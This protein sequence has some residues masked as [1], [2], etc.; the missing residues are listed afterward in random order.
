[1]NFLNTFRGRLL[2]ILAILLIATLGVQYFLNLQTEKRNEELREM[3]E[4]ALVA[5]IALGFNSMSSSDRL[6]DFVQREGQPFFD[7]RVTSRIKDIIV[8]NNDWQVNDSLN[9]AYLPFYDEKNNP[10]KRSLKDL[11]DLPP[12]MEA[13]R[14]GEDSK[15]FPNANAA[16]ETTDDEAHAIPIETDQGRFH[17][18]VVLK[19]DKRITDRAAQPLIYMLAL[20]LLSTLITIFLVW[21]FTRPIANLSEAARRVAEGDLSVRVADAD[22]GDE[23]GQLAWRFNEMTAQLEKKGE[24]EA[25]LQQAEK[26]AVVG[27]LG[28]AIAHEIR[29]PL[30]YINLTLDHLRAKFAP[31]ESGKREDFEK[32]TAQLKTEVA[33][34]NQ[35]IG[36]FLNYSRPAKANLQPLDVRH[37]VQD[38]L[39]IVEGQA[40]ELDIKISLAERE[41]VPQIL[42]DAEFL[43]SVFNNLFINA[44]QTMETTGGNLN[45]VISAAQEFVAVEVTDTG[46]GIPDENLSKIFEP[47]FSTKETGTGLGLAIVKKIVDV[48]NGMIDVESNLNE[49]TRFTVKLPKARN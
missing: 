40:A 32:L 45:V 7:E 33:R 19:N 13:D 30:N 27:R 43:R 11:T 25:Q 6:E 4:Q 46:T 49:G 23:I 17:V 28:S 5:G 15:N 10:Q 22:R 26:S 24:L 16:N 1:M 48:H 14:L 2:I 39:R 20:L 41:A 18:M 47:Y 42:G 34:I 35:Q 44:V 38:S 37:V 3:Q 36:D 9:P 12:L 31:E 21:R 8:I 29:N